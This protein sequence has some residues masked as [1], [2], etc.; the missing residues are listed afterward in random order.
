LQFK[1]FPGADVRRKLAQ[2]GVRVLE[3]VPDSAL[4]VSFHQSP[5]LR[6]LNITWTGQLTAADR[7]APGLETAP[8]F[9]VAFHSDVP[10]EDAERLL[11]GFRV[12]GAGPLPNHVGPASWPVDAPHYLVAADHAR[13][14]QL[15]ALDEVS[16]IVPGGMQMAGSRRP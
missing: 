6:G 16:Y 9:L 5:D 14:P 3:N 12:M 13:L 4:M 8:A 2:R 10:K 15:A 1:D 7:M 11:E